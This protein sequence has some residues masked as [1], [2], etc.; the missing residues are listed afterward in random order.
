MISIDKCREILGEEI[1]LTDAELEHLRGT[2]YKLA[3]IAVDLV[4]DGH[5]P[6]LLSAIEGK[7]REE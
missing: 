6:D 7:S 1:E 5:G 2:L 4:F 3:E